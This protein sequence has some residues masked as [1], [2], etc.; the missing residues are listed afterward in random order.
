ML[1]HLTV[2][3]DSADGKPAATATPTDQPP[4]DTVPDKAPERTVAVIDPGAV[5]DLALGETLVLPLLTAAAPGGEF[6]D[7]A[8]A[9]L[10]ALD[11]RLTAAGPEHFA[12]FVETRIAPAPGSASLPPEI[13]EAE[14]A[15][16]DRLTETMA[17]LGLGRAEPLAI[18]PA[19]APLAPGVTLAVT[20]ITLPQA[21]PPV[22]ALTPGAP[23]DLHAFSFG[24]GTGPRDF[25][26]TDPRLRQSTEGMIDFWTSPE[27]AQLKGYDPTLIEIGDGDETAL[28]LHL[29]DNRMGLAVW[30]G[31]PGL[32][33][34]L[35]HDFSANR[36]YHITLTATLAGIGL[37]VDGQSLGPLLPLPLGRAAPL[38]LRLGD[39]AQGQSRY[40]GRIGHLRLWHR[41]PAAD[42]LAR[43]GSVDFI[44]P[45]TDPLADAASAVIRWNAQRGQ[46]EMHDLPRIETPAAGW[47]AP[48]PDGDIHLLNAGDFLAEG[49]A[50]VFSPMQADWQAQ[51]LSRA[52]QPPADGEP[53]AFGAWEDAQNNP[54][55]AVRHAFRLIPDQGIDLDALRRP[56]PSR[57]GIK[58]PRKFEW[59]LPNWGL[60]V[61]SDAKGVLAITQTVCT[62]DQRAGDRWTCPDDA[63]FAGRR[64]VVFD[65]DEYLTGLGWQRSDSGI[66]NLYFITNKRITPKMGGDLQPGETLIEDYRQI[67]PAGV[68]PSQF[69]AY[70][71]AGRMIDFGLDFDARHRLPG[72]TLISETG[73]AMRFVRQSADRLESAEGDLG[74]LAGFP[75]A[76]PKGETLLTMPAEGRLQISGLPGELLRLP[77]RPPAVPGTAFNDTF[78]SLS[79]AVNLQAS[80]TGYDAVSMDP[81][82]LVRSGASHPVFRL[83]D[84]DSR[85]YYDANRIFV[86]RGL[87]YFPEFT[88]ETQARVTT[89]DTYS[90]YADSFS[91]TVSF[92]IGGKAAPGS[93][94]ASTTMTSARKSIAE[95]KLSR[96]RGLARAVFYD[97]VLDPQHMELDDLFAAEAARLPVNGGYDAFIETFGTHYPVAVVYG[98]LGVLE[99]DATE[100]MRQDM[101]QHGISIKLEASVMLD[102]ASKTNASFGYEHSSE[103]AE[104]FREV[105]GS[106]TENFYW[107][108]GTH[109][110]ASNAGWTVG[111]DGVVPVHV[112][113]RPIWELLSPLN[114]DDPAVY[115]LAR[116][117]LRAKVEGRLARAGIGLPGGADEGTYVEEVPVGCVGRAGDE[118]GAKSV[119]GERS[120]RPGAVALTAKP[121]KMF[122]MVGMA[123]FDGAQGLLRNLVAHQIDPDEDY[124]ALLVQCPSQINLL[125]RSP[126]AASNALY[127]FQMS[128]DDILSGRAS[129]DVLDRIDLESRVIHP[130]VDQNSREVKSKAFL[131]GLTLGISVLVDELT[132]DDG[133]PLVRIGEKV[134][135][136]KGMAQSGF[137]LRAALCDPGG[138]CPLSTADL[139]RLSGRWLRK[140]VQIP[141]AL[142]C[143]SGTPPVPDYAC[144]PRRVDYSLRIVK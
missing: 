2:P 6:S 11:H 63:R 124:K 122:P 13:A 22:W 57:F 26:L 65:T 52:A 61:R 71:E 132:N 14:A 83:P 29:L 108:G 96:T 138:E 43:L 119:P 21:L 66:R 109:A 144:L 77:D 116:Q 123:V 87:H 42:D 110:G 137:N 38:R 111:T 130:P 41:I 64:L 8:R 40:Q 44:P 70:F 134:F 50:P 48:L 106:Q 128:A 69:I 25:A 62:T 125:E 35:P 56:P 23:D 140:S 55:F 39:D 20:R 9:L 47:Y 120:V 46:M 102:A 114:F 84:G 131:A 76:S 31:I 97:L 7:E 129:Y 36:P 88:G 67:L 27:W 94:S 99:I 113:L 121:V 90:E 19:E 93:F 75:G 30:T 37:Q 32:T 117:S 33:L 24:Q 98:G 115:V 103:H 60:A 91:D 18:R 86:P 136:P 139:D 126:Y 54:A 143:G 104:T 127:R 53:G 118:P 58:T 101:R 135:R 79:K 17:E 72:V 112:Q 59:G 107:I 142:A 95:E 51:S 68:R 105:M 82:H 3:A 85:D 34:A 89:S 80:F 1:A 10:Q 12:L 73:V 15:L 141:R 45:E 92:G 49:Q 81:L 4:P 74:F 16:L 133:S 28:S 78:V 100:S 5:E